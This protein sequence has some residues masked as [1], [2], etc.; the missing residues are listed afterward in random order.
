MGETLG[1]PG[2][3]DGTG[4]APSLF[5]GGT[6][7]SDRQQEKISILS[8]LDTGRAS[9]RSGLKIGRPVLSVFAGLLL[10]C[11]AIIAMRWEPFQEAPARPVE[12]V[13]P[14]STPESPAA[15]VAQESQAATIENVSL[16][17][18]SEDAAREVMGGEHDT[19]TGQA[20]DL[21]SPES[22]SR[23]SLMALA[24]PGS[25]ARPHSVKADSG[26]EAR[27]AQKG[28][29]V[30][31]RQ[32]HSAEKKYSTAVTDSDAALLAA[33]VAHDTGR[34]ITTKQASASSTKRRNGSAGKG[35]KVFDPERDVVVDDKTVSTAELVR[36][37]GTLGLLEGFLCKTRV[38]SS[39]QGSD[40]ECP[41]PAEPAL[42]GG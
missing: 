16:A 28:D 35:N 10:A 23:V 26:D 37:C 32:S 11:S 15:V 25:V 8:S 34:P 38:C 7:K 21:S 39:R 18:S 1:S 33:L 14:Q 24:E 13:M 31:R 41:K 12:A 22:E 17:S 30:K 2:P 3:V 20:K 29:A 19:G 42:R 4:K 6:V 27:T 5:S 40:P 36:R 9:R